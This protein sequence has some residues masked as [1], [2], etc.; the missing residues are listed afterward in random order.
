MQTKEAKR[1]HDTPLQ[2][3]SHHEVLKAK[4]KAIENKIAVQQPKILQLA[5]EIHAVEILMGRNED[6]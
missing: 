2:F 4:L 6:A 1:Q 5:M 3:S